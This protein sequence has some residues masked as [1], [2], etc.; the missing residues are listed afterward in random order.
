MPLFYG[1]PL[2]GL[3]MN[4]YEEVQGSSF[5]TLED[6]Q[7][8]YTIPFFF[9][10][11]YD[12]EEEFVWLTSINYLSIYL[13]MRVLGLSFSAY[14]QFLLGMLSTILAINLLGYYSMVESVF[15]PLDKGEDVEKEILLKY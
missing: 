15:L 11:N 14:Q 7:Q 10:V 4:F 1:D 3:D 12:I 5:Y 13:L 6:E 8:L 2:L 9:W